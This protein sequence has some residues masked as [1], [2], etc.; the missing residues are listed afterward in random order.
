MDEEQRQPEPQRRGISIGFIISL[1]LVIGLIVLMATLLFGN[2]NSSTTLNEVQ[3]IQALEN[4]RVLTIESTPK[5]QTLVT[6]EGKYEYTDKN[7]VARTGR[8]YVA[9]QWDTYYDTEHQYFYTNESTRKPLE[10]ISQGVEFTYLSMRDHKIVEGKPIEKTHPTSKKIDPELQKQI[11]I[12]NA[13]SNAKNKSVKPGYKKKR[14]EEIAKAKQ[15]HRREII[16]KDIKR[17]R[18]ERYKKEN[19]RYE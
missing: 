16:K 1:I 12:I 8:Y 17:Q 19:S 2:F 10:L 15:K 6:L 11:N 9:I 5:E 3:F 14:K 7:G 4:D 13:K 18:I